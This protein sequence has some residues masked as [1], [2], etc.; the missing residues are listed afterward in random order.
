MYFETQL[1]NIF[2]LGF[3]NFPPL[4]QKFMIKTIQTGS[5]HG[6]KSLGHGTEKYLRYGFNE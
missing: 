3:R 2:Q 5:R 4:L 1:S 6:A